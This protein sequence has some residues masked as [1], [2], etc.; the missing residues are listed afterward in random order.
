[1][2]C[3]IDERAGPAVDLGII[4]L[5]CNVLLDLLHVC[6]PVN[7]RVL[8]MYV[9]LKCILCQGRYNSPL[10][11]IFQMINPVSPASARSSNGQTHL[12]CRGSFATSKHSRTIFILQSVANRSDGQPC[13]MKP[14][15]WSL[16]QG[17]LKLALHKQTLYCVRIKLHMRKR[18]ILR[19]SSLRGDSET[20]PSDAQDAST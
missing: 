18:H 3:R 13:Q 5:P 17:R 2:G 15:I 4:S 9:S 7:L 11:G 19:I 12:V 14:Q 8:D 6:F 20:Q 16:K 1:M 10:H